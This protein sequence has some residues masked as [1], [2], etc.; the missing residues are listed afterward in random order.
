MG[1]HRIAVTALSL[2]LLALGCGSSDG[3]S[4]A[5]GTGGAAGSGSGG[6][7]GSGGCAATSADALMECVEQTRLE[8]DVKLIAQPR[9]PGSPH[10]QT[11]QDLCAD[12][13]EQYG[14]EVERQKYATGVNV[15]GRMAGQTLPQE[16]VIVSAHYDHIAGCPGADDN[17]SGVAAV[18]ETARVL[19]QAKFQRTLVVAC[20]DEEEAGLIG[21]EA[22]AA[23]AAQQGDNII[24]MVSLEM[25]G[26][27]DD[28]PNTQS[29]PAGFNL[30]FGDEYAKIEDNQFRADFVAIVSIDS[31]TTTA[32]A[33][34]SHAETSGPPTALLILDSAQAQ[35]PLLADLGRSDHAAFWQYG[36]PALMVTD[37]SNFRYA[38][39]H[40]TG[41][42]DVP[43]LLD[44]GFMA[45]IT[46]ADLGAQV[47]A[48]GL[49]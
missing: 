38:Q 15:I 49:D 48:L 33:I 3:G 28:A 5:A 9:P 42:D 19:S 27:R 29:V 11:V 34:R 39:Y 7:G 21:S 31:A 41:G 22:Y 6:A 8:S 30:L 13:F 25:I 2:S 45:A 40:C 18:L 37:T 43:E 26:Y 47:D 23:R 46:R 1:I 32:N 16:Q 35:S 44:F 36:F 14:F 12:R 20:W 10:W 17:A 4:E 24:N